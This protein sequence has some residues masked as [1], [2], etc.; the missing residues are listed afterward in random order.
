MSPIDFYK[1]LSDET[2][3]RCILLIFKQEELCVCELTEALNEIQPKISI[4]DF[5]VH[6]KMNQSVGV[7]P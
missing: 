3:L 7:C 1:C 4:S 2:R 6:T 5:L